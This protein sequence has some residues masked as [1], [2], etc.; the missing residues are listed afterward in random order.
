MKNINL[1]NPYVKWIGGTFLL[2]L[3]IL[4]VLIMRLK[5]A[6]DRAIQAC[7]KAFGSMDDVQKDAIRQIVAAFHRYGD[8]DPNKL[9]YIL[10]TAWHES[11]L[12]PIQERQAAPNQTDLYNKQARYW[13]TGYYGRGFVQL[14]WKENY[15]KMSTAL[16]LDLVARPELA[17]HPTYAARILVYG[18]MNGSFT[19]IPLSKF[20]NP[21]Q[22]DF[23]QA[24]LVVN[25][26]DR[27]ER[28]EQYAQFLV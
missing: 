11:S 8:G 25:G 3:F 19:G 13:H 23:Y 24:R 27:A 15:Q 1:E 10:A 2:V 18:M 6:Q 28:I 17:L 26:L 9:A 4:L 22:Q 7:T 14:T 20:I 5:L 21:Q 12:R 16:G